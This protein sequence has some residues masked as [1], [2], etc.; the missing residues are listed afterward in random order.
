MRRKLMPA[1]KRHQRRAPRPRVRNTQVRAAGPESSST[2]A[3][4]NHRDNRLANGGNQFSSEPPDQA[5]CVGPQPR[6]RGRQHASCGST[7]RPVHRSAP[8]ISLQRVLRLP[9]GDRPHD[10]VFGAFLT[11]PVCHFDADSGHFFLAV[12]TLDQDPVNG[13]FTG[14]NRLDLAVSDTVRSDR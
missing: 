12:L 2:F 8:T 11:D 4:L 13:Q 6:A 5:L 9:A 10:G 14:K 7:T 3:G 1:P